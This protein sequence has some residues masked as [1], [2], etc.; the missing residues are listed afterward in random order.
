MIKSY[1]STFEVKWHTHFVLAKESYKQL[2]HA[3]T[4]PYDEDEPVVHEDF[5]AY[6]Y[7]APGA[8]VVVLLNPTVLR[9]NLEPDRLNS[10][11]FLE[12]LF[13]FHNLQ[14]QAQPIR[15]H[16]DDEEGRICDPDGQRGTRYTRLFCP[17]QE[18]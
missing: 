12:N 10:L 1:H 4:A 18:E 8:H 9:G 7:S 2:G 11:N 16:S 3:A 14:S 15:P 6:L 5:V 17:S 13:A